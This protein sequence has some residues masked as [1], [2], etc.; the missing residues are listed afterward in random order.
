M[1]SESVAYVL[2]YDN[3]MMNGTQT[4]GNLGT[5]PLIIIPAICKQKGGP[6]GDPESCAKYGMGYVTLSM[7]VTCPSLSVSIF[8]KP[9][10]IS[11]YHDTLLV[12]IR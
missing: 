10:L 12:S 2:L 9:F 1:T 11:V 7:T 3:V 8:F 5:M 6:F 4:P